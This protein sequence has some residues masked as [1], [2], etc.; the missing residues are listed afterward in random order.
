MGLYD[1]AVPLQHSGFES[2]TIEFK[3]GKSLCV[4]YLACT[5][6]VLSGCEQTCRR[7]VIEGSDSTLHCVSCPADTYPGHFNAKGY[8]GFW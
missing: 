8:N 3:H 4:V 6:A 7:Q 2:F 5:A 1:F